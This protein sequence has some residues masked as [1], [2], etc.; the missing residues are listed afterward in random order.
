MFVAYTLYYYLI[1]SL[2][3][4]YLNMHSAIAYVKKGVLFSIAK[5]ADVCSLYIIL[6]FDCKPMFYLFKHA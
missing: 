1:V 3:F 4:A 6:F 2:S 5:V